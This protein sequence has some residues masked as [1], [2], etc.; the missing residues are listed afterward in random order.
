MSDEATHELK[1]ESLYFRD[2]LDGSKTFELRRMDRPFR[3]GDR[4]CLREWLPTTQSY[5]GRS[6][7]RRISY[8]LSGADRFGLPGEFGI[9]GLED[10]RISELEATIANERTV[11][12]IAEADLSKELT[13]QRD[14][15]D[16]LWKRIFTVDTEN[17]KLRGL[18]RLLSGE[19]VGVSTDICGQTTYGYGTLSDYGYWEFP[20]PVEAVR[21]VQ[22]EAKLRTVEQAA[23]ELY[24]DLLRQQQLHADC[25][26]HH[27]AA[28]T[29]AEARGVNHILV[30]LAAT[31]P[32]TA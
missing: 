25:N 13:E 23:R 7:F 9:L 15:N 8:V 16:E 24:A 14:K 30:A 4:L 21:K 1:C 17:A 28:I 5:T 6:C 22:A 2:V 29:R 11:H 20:V 3:V 31:P 26:E 18:Q 10:A 27:A 12:T 19:Q 32:E